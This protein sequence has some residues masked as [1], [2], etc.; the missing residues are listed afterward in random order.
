MLNYS[1]RGEKRL[2]GLKETCCCVS[3]TD[4]ATK[5]PH[6]RPKSYECLHKVTAVMG[7]IVVAV[8]RGQRCPLTDCKDKGRDRSKNCW[9][10]NDRTG[11]EI[12][13]G[14]SRNLF[15]RLFLFFPWKFELPDLNL[16]AR[17][18]DRLVCVESGLMSR[19]F[20]LM[21]WNQVFLP[22]FYEFRKRSSFTTE[23]QYTKLR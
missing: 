17:P 18:K 11:E 6:R 1:K 19:R 3:C 20:L 7:V 13:G 9:W 21:R 22:N 14:G 5:N 4:S 12:Q 10:D 16:R 23:K 15:S 8:S 2:N